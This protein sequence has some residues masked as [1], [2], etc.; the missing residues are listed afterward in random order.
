MYVDGC[1]GY[2]NYVL[3]YD[4]TD[5]ANITHLTLQ[6]KENLTCCGNNEVH[7]VFEDEFTDV[8]WGIDNDGQESCMWTH[9]TMYYTELKMKS[10]DAYSHFQKLLNFDQLNT[11]DPS[12]NEKHT[13][14]F[15]QLTEL[16]RKE[17][18]QVI[19]DQVVL[20]K[21][22]GNIVQQIYSWKSQSMLDD[23]NEKAAWWKYRDTINK[24]WKEGCGF[25]KLASLGKETYQTW[26]KDCHCLVIQCGL[27]E[28]RFHT[29]QTNIKHSTEWITKHFGNGTSPELVTEAENEIYQ[30]LDYSGPIEIYKNNQLVKKFDTMT[31]LSWDNLMNAI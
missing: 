26:G 2:D 19:V 25:W 23:E 17:Q 20:L 9:M 6:T 30:Q 29:Q 10:S 16:L 3:F 15:N 5:P 18:R 4:F 7:D 21:R 11:S 1:D 12:F 13:V 27:A 14:L 28:I 31:N 24:L 8:Q 22:V